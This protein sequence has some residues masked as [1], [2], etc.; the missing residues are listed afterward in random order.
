MFKVKLLSFFETWC[1]IKIKIFCQLHVVYI[2]SCLL[3]NQVNIFWNTCFLIAALFF[4]LGI[5][6]L[7]HELSFKCCFCCLIHKRIIMLKHFLFIIFMSISRSRSFYVVL[8]DFFFLSSFSLWLIV[9]SHEFGH[10]FSFAY[11]LECSMSYYFHMKNVNNFQIA[12][13]HLPRVLL[14]IGVAHK[15]IAFSK[16]HVFQQNFWVRCQ[17]L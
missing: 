12:K 15:S 10:T 3:R 9:W 8:S 2:Q 16:K 1:E 13:V 7:F 17:T 14:S 6:W 5:T 11:F 4:Q